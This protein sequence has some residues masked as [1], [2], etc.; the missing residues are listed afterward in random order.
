MLVSG[1]MKANKKINKIEK[2]NRFKKRKK[3]KGVYSTLLNF[4][5]HVISRRKR[6][7]KKKK[8][9][10]TWLTILLWYY[11]VLVLLVVFSQYNKGDASITHGVPAFERK[12]RKKMSN[13]QPKHI[14]LKNL[15]E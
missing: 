8:K 1:L 13:T 14:Y 12:R 9:K 15:I 4:I 2:P 3:E 6:T 7:R 5:H 11:I 10:K